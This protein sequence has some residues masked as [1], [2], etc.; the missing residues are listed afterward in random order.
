[1]T[2]YSSKESQ[3]EGLHLCK[4]QIF[5]AHAGNDNGAEDAAA[6]PTGVDGASNEQY[7]DDQ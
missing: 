2:S 7:K 4:E 5:A 1:M 3:S 6:K